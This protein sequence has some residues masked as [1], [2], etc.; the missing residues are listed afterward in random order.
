MQ[1]ECETLQVN[2]RNQLLR[3]VYNDVISNSI[4]KGGVV[5]LC[6]NSNITTIVALA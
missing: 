2:P 5:Y 3:F 1:H 6:A 4:K